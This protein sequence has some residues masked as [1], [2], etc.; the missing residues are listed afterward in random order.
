MKS[1]YLRQVDFHI[2]TE[3]EEDEIRDFQRRHIAKSW[4]KRFLIIFAVIGI[5][6]SFQMIARLTIPHMFGSKKTIERLLSIGIGSFAAINFLSWLELL[7][8]CKVIFDIKTAKV[9][10]LRVKKKMIIENCTV[11]REKYRYLICEDGEDFI[12]DR[13][14]VRGGISYSNIK[15]GQTV[16]VE[17]LHDDG[18]YRYYYVA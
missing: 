12:L 1:I 14:E 17:R 10:R 16:Y 7:F 11:T 2:P 9:A 6:V 15:E 8:E 4:A 13:I 5:I 3:E 18:H